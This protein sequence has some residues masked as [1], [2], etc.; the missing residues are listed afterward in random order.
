MKNQNNIFSQSNKTQ[1]SSGFT[2]QIHTHLSGEV[3][4]LLLFLFL[5]VRVEFILNEMKYILNKHF[6]F[7]GVQFSGLL[8]VLIIMEITAGVMAFMFS[9][10]VKHSH[11][12]THTHTHRCLCNSAVFLMCVCVCCRWQTSWRTSISASTLSMSTPGAQVKKSPSNY[13]TT[14]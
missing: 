4:T 8:T 5:R 2:G 1:T 14:L 10:R 11:T 9:D 12:H 6:C 13:S 3:L 7:S